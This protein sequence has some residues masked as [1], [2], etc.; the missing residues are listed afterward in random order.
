MKN[1]NQK[2]SFLVE[3]MVGLLVSITGIMA[4]VA[5]FSQFEGQ[6][7]TTTQVS[8]SVTNAAL[9]MFPIQ[10]YGKISGFGINNTSLLGCNVLTHDA[11]TGS[12][13]SF[14]LAPLLITGRNDNEN[15]TIQFVVGNATNYY[16][17]NTLTSAMANSLSNFELDS[18]FGINV[19]ENV[20]VGQPGSDCT[21]RQVTGLPTD[22]GLTNQV[23]HSGTTYL[24]ASGVS[25]A[26]I[27]NASTGMGIAYSG[28]AKLINVGT[29]PQV[30]TFSV[31]NN[32]LFQSVNTGIA[33]TSTNQ[34][35]GDNIVALKAVYG[36]DTN[37]DGSV[38][39]WTNVTPATA[40]LRQILGFR[41]AVISRA[42]L[43]EKTSGGTCNVT[44]VSNISW[45]GGNIDIS[46]LPDWGCYRYRIIQTTVPLKNAM[47][48]NS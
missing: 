32:Q 24:N 45:L 12:S 36:L 26:A 22:I 3:L 44:T 5:V 41:V 35:I 33:S 39:T 4:M 40:D 31:N 13:S 48:S 1:I 8:E 20:I 14:I 27:H 6:K 43:K 2:G 46:G 23:I 15:D 10:H 29:N 47:W 11:Q 38:D 37:A 30:I 19:G 34:V 7:R 9:S 16:A 25:T 42:P 21:M 17:A 28:G 18:R